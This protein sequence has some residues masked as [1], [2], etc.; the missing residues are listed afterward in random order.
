MGS[1]TLSQLV[2]PGESSPNFP[3]EKSHR[4]NTVVKKAFTVSLFVFCEGNCFSSRERINRLQLVDM[5]QIENRNTIVPL[6]KKKSLINK[7]DNNNNNNNNNN[8]R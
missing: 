4:D 5:K 7:Y 8:N 3:S 6:I 1:A 2:F